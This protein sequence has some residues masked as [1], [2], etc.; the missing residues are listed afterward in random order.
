M[1]NARPR[2]RSGSPGDAG[3]E[4]GN[5]PQRPLGFRRRAGATGSWWSE[6]ACRLP[7]GVPGRATAGSRG[8]A[9]R[10]RSVPPAVAERLS[11]LFS[12]PSDAPEGMDVVFH[13][14]ATPSGLSC[15]LA[16]AGME[17]TRRGDE[18]VRRDDRPR[19]PLGCDFHARR[20]QLI[21][22][23]VGQIAPIAPVRA[24][25]SEPHREGARA[26]A[27]RALDALITEEVAFADLPGAVPA[28][29]PAPGLA[30]AIRY[31]E[32]ALRTDRRL[33]FTEK[34]ACP[35]MPSRCAIAS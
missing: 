34:E 19:R 12:A 3:G 29:L 1:L 31:D 30:T 8:D 6:P 28:L 22:S 5:R 27:R 2:R 33:H 32:A 35:C 16:A 21:S 15:A 4:H 11:A 10:C 14:S 26:P 17:A 23:Q 7:G 24:G 20:L 18:L 13:C 25:I 9:R